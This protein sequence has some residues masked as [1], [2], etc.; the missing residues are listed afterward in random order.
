MKLQNQVAVVTGAARGVGLAVAEAFV[1]EGASVLLA[2]LDG[3]A[4]H[5]AAARI[6]AA[7][8]RAISIA[9]DV[10]SKADCATMMQAAAD[11]LGPV[12]I[13]VCNAGIV[14]KAADIEDIAPETWHQVI[15][16]NLMGCIY[17]TQIFAPHGVSGG[18]GQWRQRRN[19]L[20][21]DQNRRVVPHQARGEAAGAVRR[22]RE[23]HCPGCYPN[24]NDRRVAIRP[25]GEGVDPIGPI[26]RCYGYRRGS[27][28]SRLGR[29][30]LRHGD[31]PGC[32]RGA[33]H[34]VRAMTGTYTR[35]R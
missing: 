27:A 16:V 34:E 22:H 3:N 7:P 30:W 26:W 13:V 23:R 12:D 14:R 2:D 35:S 18:R 25:I 20:L 4:V 24:R 29:R 8:R 19:D 9:A 21:R 10:S 31:D 32:K 17:P 28:L 1:R 11:Q 33:V 5:E 15:G 6:G